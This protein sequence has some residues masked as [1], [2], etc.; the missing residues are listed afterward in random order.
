MDN[1]M[2]VI[3]SKESVVILNVK[4]TDIFVHKMVLV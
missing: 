3:E 4:L 1:L 2:G